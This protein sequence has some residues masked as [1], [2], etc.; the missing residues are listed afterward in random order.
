MFRLEETERLQQSGRVEGYR[1][2]YLSQTVLSLERALGSRWNAAIVFVH[3]RNHDMVALVDRNLAAD[4]TVV[5]DVLVLDRFGQPVS[6]QGQRLVL[7][8]LAISNED[9]LAVQ[10]ALK[11]GT[12]VRDPLVPM[13]YAPPGM[14]PADLA[15]LRYDPDLVLTNVPD[16]TRRL[17]QVQLRLDARYRTWWAGASATVSSL[18]GN[19]NVVSG[20]DDYT[21]GGP[22]PWVRL[23][24]QYNF[25]GA[26]NNQSQFEGKVYLGAQLP[27]RMR[28]GLVFS[29][30]TG[31]RVTPTLLISSLLSDYAVVVP[32]AGDP[33]RADTLPF[34]AFLFRSLTGQRVFLQPRGAY[35]YEAR[36][37][38]DLHLERSFSRAPRE[39]VL[40][41]DVFN[42]LGDRSV[43]GIQY[44]VNTAGIFSG[45]DYGRV[46]SRVAPRTL[47]VGAGVKF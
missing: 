43:T 30:A 14:S 38:L 8:R 28:G 27:A 33:A 10:Q 23:N 20:P 25:Y 37:S 16:A 2:P 36:A 12:L 47:R 4:Y 21:T 17:W 6:F 39:V 42:L 5:Q 11:Q 45:D 29:Y 35:R 3:R 19:F 22:G 32:R 40:V 44:L 13:L 7:E 18:N 24:E 41:A 34:H 1:Q 46:R 15:A 31:D 9:L 26:L